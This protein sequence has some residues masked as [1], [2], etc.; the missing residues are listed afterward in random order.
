MAVRE[1]PVA[2]ALIAVTAALAW[3]GCSVEKHYAVLSF[4]FDGVPEPVPAEAEGTDA[5]RARSAASGAPVS[6]HTA[7]I[8]RRCATCHG[9][10]VTFGF[11][12]KGFADL[13]GGACVRC[14]EHVLGTAF[15][16]GPAAAREC[17]AC[18]DPHESRYPMLLVNASPAL[19]TQC[20]AAELKMEP[21]IAGH[22][23]AARD[24]L[25]CHGAHGGDDRYFLRS[26]E[27]EG[28]SPGRPP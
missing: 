11:T 8:E 15:V 22:E 17:T 1:R 23:D 21:I 14:H 5:Q 27:Q 18:H 20:H 10:S 28:G 25:E 19:C 12:A 3:G 26:A 24:C 7:Y 9:E 6:R 16:H 4:F 2:A 13:D